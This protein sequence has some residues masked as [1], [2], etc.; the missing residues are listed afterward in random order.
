MSSSLFSQ[1][2][3]EI[4]KLELR[5]NVYNLVKRFSGSNFHDLERKSNIPMSTLQYHLN[6][7]TKHG[8]ITIQ[9]DGNKIRYFTKQL[10]SQDK[11]ILILLRQKPIRRI[12]L[13]LLN[14]K[15]CT[16]KE[17]IDFLKISPSTASYYI[18]N[19]IKNNVLETIQSKLRIKYTL[20]INEEEIISLLVTYKDSFFDKLVDQ[21]IEMWNFKV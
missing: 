9:K 5:R 11:R 21:T 15:E 13:L 10:N 12:L 2:E 1:K 19:L 18:S 14:N 20:A 6:Y 8:L 17:I 3:H 4:L 16:Q 7:L